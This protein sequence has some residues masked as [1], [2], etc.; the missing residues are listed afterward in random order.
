MHCKMVNKLFMMIKSF[1]ECEKL[2]NDYG[3]G[4]KLYHGEINLLEIIY[5]NPEV[6][7]VELSRMMG[8]TR[9]AVTQLGNRLI[10]KGIIEKQCLEGNK[11]SKR[12]AMTALGVKVHKSYRAYHEQANREVCE[13]LSTLDKHETKTISQFLDKISTLHI[14]EFECGCN[15]DCSVYNEEGERINA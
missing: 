10:E 4:I 11:K 13:Y 2:P 7:P 6:T 15:D 12:Y 1:A 3:T 9:G 8:I 14:S 5:K